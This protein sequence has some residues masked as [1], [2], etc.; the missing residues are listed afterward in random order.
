MIPLLF[1]IIVALTLSLL[2]Y[3]ILNTTPPTETAVPSRRA[4]KFENASELGM[5]DINE[6]YLAQNHIK[7]QLYGPS[8][9]W[10]YWNLSRTKW[11]ETCTVYGIKPDMRRLVLRVHEIGQGTHFSDIG[12]GSIVGQYRFQL[13][14]H[15]SYYVSLGLKYHQRFIPIITSNFITPPG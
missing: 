1:I 7:I 8:L 4:F 13:E 11:E 3:W 12:A 6:F 14:P 9:G 2:V 15:K 5:H 10:V